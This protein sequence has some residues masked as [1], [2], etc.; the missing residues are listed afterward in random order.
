MVLVVCCAATVYAARVSPAKLDV[1]QAAGT[2]ESYALT[3]TND[4]DAEEAVSIYTGDWSR[5]EDGTYDWS[6]PVDGARW[7]FDRQFDAGEEVEIRY[8]VRLT[9]A[10]ELPVQGL[11][12]SGSPQ[13]DG[14]VQG[15]DVLGD[16]AVGDGPA[17]PGAGDPVW[18]GRT[19]ETIDPNGWATVALTIQAGAAFDGLAIVESF[20]ERAEVLD[21]DASGARLETVNRSSTGW[22]AVSRAQLVLEPGES[23]TVEVTIATP[24]DYEGTYWSVVF[25]ESC[26][27]VEE[28]GGMR[29]LNCYRSAIRVYVTAPETGVLEGA[30][31]AV[32]VSE[33]VPLTI[34][35]TFE[36]TGNVELVVTG[37][38]EVIDRTGETVRDFAIA[39]FKVLPGSSRIVVTIDETGAAPLPADIYQAV[40]SFD[41]GGDGPV[42]GVRGFRVR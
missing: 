28:R 9:A 38:I 13:F 22:I 39:E 1:V 5:L 25:A 18:I 12:R 27:D 4:G 36:N 42:V 34:G 7:V 41:Y 35:S 40:V 15:V 24:D 31:T 17:G 23:R 10:L 3:I 16:E 33:T 14:A 6:L 8:A 11:F 26:P 20:S 2:V 32:E 29:V 19:L 21:L 30:V 37:D